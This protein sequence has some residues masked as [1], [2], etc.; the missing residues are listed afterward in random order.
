MLKNHTHRGTSQQVHLITT[1][2]LQTFDSLRT[3]AMSDASMTLELWLRTPNKPNYSACCVFLVTLPFKGTVDTNALS[4]TPSP[5]CHFNSIFCYFIQRGIRK[6]LDTGRNVTDLVL[7]NN[8][9]PF[10]SAS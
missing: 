4:C 3:N 10:C 8:N 7:R 2:F 6:S 5:S 9:L 1:S